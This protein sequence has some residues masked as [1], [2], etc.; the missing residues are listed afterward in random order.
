M[1]KDDFCLNFPVAKLVDS[2]S[3]EDLTKLQNIVRD[4]VL[5]RIDERLKTGVFAT[6]SDREKELIDNGMR[7]TAIK[8]YRDRNPGVS[9]YEA[10]T[11]LDKYPS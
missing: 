3:N 6:I 10:K 9:V 8:E 1:A 11:I 5:K 2:L 7:V 4:V